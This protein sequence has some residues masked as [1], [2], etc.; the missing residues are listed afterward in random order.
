MSGLLPCPFCGS[1]AVYSGSLTSPPLN[2]VLCTGCPA[3]TRPFPEQQAGIAWNTRA[4]NPAPTLLEALIDISNRILCPVGPA[5]T[6]DE[7][8]E[9]AS[10]AIN[11]ATGGQQ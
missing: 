9:I 5:P 7:V 2:H 6:L 4:N 11:A 10:A 1:A 3:G 8:Q